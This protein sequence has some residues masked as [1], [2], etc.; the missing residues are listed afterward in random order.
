[1]QSSPGGVLVTDFPTSNSRRQKSRRKG[2]SGPVFGG[3]VVFLWA[4]IFS[5]AQSLTKVTG[6]ANLPLDLVMGIGIGLIGGLA[7]ALLVWL[8]LFFVFGRRH[9]PGGVTLLGV[10]MLIAAAGALPASGLKVVGAAFGAEQSAQDTIRTRADA[11]RD[12]ATERLREARDALVKE[13][14]FETAALIEAGGL[15]RARRKVQTLREMVA[16]SEAEDDRLRSQARAE[17]AALPV[18]GPRRAIILREFDAGV[19]AEKADTKIGADLSLMLFDEMDAQ[20]DILE[21]RRWVVQYGE[22]AF[23]STSDMNA[24]NMHVRRIDE[25]SDALDERAEARERKIEE[26]RQRR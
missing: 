16:Q 1:M 17:I 24:F 10:M 14:F 19:V 25:I 26:S 18:S 20:L 13:D 7:G 4:F 15:A 12:A 6:T 8:I 11:R 21:R 3:I 9:T 22:I 23:T 2:Y 5:V